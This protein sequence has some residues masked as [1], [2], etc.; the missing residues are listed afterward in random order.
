MISNY[1]I[2]KVNKIMKK[3]LGLILALPLVTFSLFSCEKNSTSKI[4]LDF[5]NIHSYKIEEISQIAEEDY[6]SLKSLTINKGN[7]MLALYYHGCG[8]WDEFRPVLINFINKYNIDVHYIEVEKF[9]GQSDKFG[10]YTVKGDMPS[11]AF[12]KGGKLQKQVIYQDNTRDAFHELSAFEKIVF[13]NVN[14]PKMYYLD[15]DVLDS[16]IA[17]NKEFN[18]YIARSGC[19]DC[20]TLNTGAIASWNNKNAK[21]TEPLYVFDIQQWRDGD[22]ETYQLIKDTYK[23]TTKYNPDFGYDLYGGA[24]PTFQHRKGNLVTDM[25]V[26]L[27]DQAGKGENE[28]DYKITTTYF[29]E[30]HLS[31][32]TF[33]NLDRSKALEGKSLTEKEY[34]KWWTGTMYDLH[35]PF[36]E[37]FFAY[38]LK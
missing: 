16:Y 24:V 18:L 29:T 32:M 31:K 7:F 19:G 21:S 1:T 9:D 13:A 28:G 27:N 33:M 6:E 12:F 17:E 8:C 3:N 4:N 26:A 5:G 22:P 2:K 14:L 25:L 38:Y 10:L 11:I 36:V 35:K 15:K 34:S 20:K 30:A 23:L 37:K